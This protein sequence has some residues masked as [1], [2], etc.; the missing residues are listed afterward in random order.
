M[1]KQNLM[2][3]FGILIFLTMSIGEATS[4]PLG[5][6]DPCPNGEIR[7]VDG[8]LS[9]NPDEYGWKLFIALNQPGDPATKCPDSDIR[10]KFGEDG[11]FG[12]DGPVLW[13]TW[14]NVRAGAVDGTFLR[15]GADPGT[16]RS[17]SAPAQK[18][19]DDVSPS[20][21]TQIVA[22]VSFQDRVRGQQ[23]G[24]AAD[25]F[26]GEGNE[27]RLNRA[28]YLFIRQEKLFDLK[29]QIK[30]V[31]EQRFDLDFPPES[32][33]IKAQWRK[34]KES[35]KPRYHW[36]EFVTP[37]GKEIWGLTALH[38]ITKDTPAWFW[39]TFEHIDNKA[40]STENEGWQTKSVDNF[41]CPGAAVDCD[42]T[43]AGIVGPWKNY[44][45]RGTQTKFVEAGQPT[46]LA[47]SQIETNFQSRSSCISCHAA[48]SVDI[49]G[50]GVAME[51]RVGL[52][53][54][55]LFLDPKTGKQ[56]KMPL[57]FLFSLGRAQPS[58]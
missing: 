55:N 46:I 40:P 50:G 49:E 13:E 54:A 24:F 36:T 39:A 25:Q 35:D 10:R 34:I 7:D 22:G 44:R 29:Q 23:S 27:I 38:I 12:A 21:L 45:L 53:D 33:A 19:K 52:P 26:V 6:N 28:A 8:L 15:G 41:S 37:Q 5:Q 56:N 20:S 14:R 9:R 57:D 51:E 43:P 17:H 11:K 1:R 2:H 30:R 42:K 16:W 58:N 32:K 4:Q 48:A 3:V 18:S 31:N 47:N